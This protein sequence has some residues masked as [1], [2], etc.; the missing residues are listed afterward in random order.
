MGKELALQRKQLRLFRRPLSTL[1]YFG[2]CAGS[3]A[4]RGVLWLA[5]HRLTLSL[6]LPALAGYI[7]LKQTGTPLLPARAHSYS[8]PQAHS[9]AQECMI[10]GKAVPVHSCQALCKMQRAMAAALSC[11]AGKA[12]S[13]MQSSRRAALS[14]LP[15]PGRAGVLHGWAVFAVVGQLCRAASEN[16]VVDIFWQGEWGM[17]HA[18]G[19]QSKEL[20]RAEVWF[21][22]CIW[23]IGL[24]ILSSIGLGTGMHS[25]LLFLFPHM[26]K[27]GGCQS[28]ASSLHNRPC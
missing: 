23:W 15:M 28:R 26:L 7:F 24:G 18:A 16:S 14:R 17:C 11:L 6:L 8:T 10:R 22:Y 12:V 25:G 13:H 4:A 21:W 5:R 20:K 19:Q 2:A 1:Y 3:A 27:V 9:M